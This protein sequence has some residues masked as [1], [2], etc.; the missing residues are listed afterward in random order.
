MHLS[1][2]QLQ[3][4]HVFDVVGMREHIYRAGLSNAVL[5]AEQVLVRMA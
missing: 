4:N 2:S 1:R 3:Q 5:R